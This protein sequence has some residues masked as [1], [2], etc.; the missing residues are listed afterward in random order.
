MEE[1]RIIERGTYRELRIA[2]GAFSRLLRRELL[3]G[4]R[5]T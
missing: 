5:A 2:E 1:G 4:F 3:V